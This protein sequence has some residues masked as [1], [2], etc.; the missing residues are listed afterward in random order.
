VFLEMPVVNQPEVMI[1]EAAK[2]FDAKGTLKDETA[3]KLI[4]K[5][6][7][8]LVSLAERA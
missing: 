2:K 4:G 5:L 8:R 3:C 7:E 1:G 6:I